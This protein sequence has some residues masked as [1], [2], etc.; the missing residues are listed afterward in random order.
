MVAV[1]DGAED[2]E[3]FVTYVAKE[4]HRYLELIE[5]HGSTDAA[6]QNWKLAPTEVSSFFV[7]FCIY[8]FFVLPPL[9]FSSSLLFSSLL[10]LSYRA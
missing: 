2:S 5:E 6:K 3:A 1:I 10:L 7:V 8:F 9:F 4:L